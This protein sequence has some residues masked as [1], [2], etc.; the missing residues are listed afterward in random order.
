M[1]QLKITKSLQIRKT[2]YRDIRK[3]FKLEKENKAIKNI[4]LRNIRNI[5]EKEEE[6]NFYKPLILSKSWSNNYI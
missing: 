2:K 1:Q 4:I 3:V 5:F 6:K